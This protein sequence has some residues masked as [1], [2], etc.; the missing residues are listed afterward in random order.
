VIVRGRRLKEEPTTD[1]HGWAFINSCEIL[2]E[3]R[4]FCPVLSQYH[5]AGTCRESVL[6]AKIMSNLP[7]AELLA[8]MES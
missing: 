6:S 1:Y 3:M 4:P 7:S 5:H 2:F 8:G